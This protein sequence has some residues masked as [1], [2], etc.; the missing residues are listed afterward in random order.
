MPKLP[1][2]RVVFPLLP[3][4]GGKCACGLANCPQI[5]KHPAV[6]WKE[7]TADSVVPLP[8]PGAGYGVRTG[9][10]PFG[11]GCIVVDLDSEAACAAFES[12]G[13]AP[14]TYTVASPRGL[15]LYFTHPGFCVRNSRSKLASKIDVRGDGGMVV[16]PGS[17]HKSGARYEL[18][19]DAPLADPP[20]WLRAW[21]EKTSTTPG[22]IA[23]HADDVEGEDL[24]YHEDLY[25][26]YLETAKPAVDG[27]GGDEQ[28]WR[29]VQRGAYDLA[30]PGD[31]VLS[32][33]RDVY[34][35]RCSPPWDE[36]ALTERVTHKV[37]QAKTIS[38][39]R[40]EEP[41]PLALASLVPS[42]W[43]DLE[44][45]KEERTPEAPT[46]PIPSDLA[47]LEK[48]LKLT[49]GSWDV[50][51]T[52][53]RFIVQ[54][55]VPE[56][57]VGMFVAKGSSLKTWMALSIGIAVAN[58]QP[59]LGTYAVR[60][61]NVLIVDF[62]SGAWQLRDRARI[63]GKHSSPGLGHAN[64]P[65][66]RIDD[67]NF[68][69]KLALICRA[70]NVGLLIIDSFAAGATGV[71]ENDANAAKPL[72]LAARFT[73]LCKCAVLIIHHAKKGEGGDERDLVRGT[74]A[75]YAGLDWAYT[76][77]PNDDNRTRMTVRNIKPFAMRPD[78]FKIALLPEA[79]G[80]VL[81]VDATEK[82]PQEEGEV[83]KN[84]IVGLLAKGPLENKELIARAL[85]MR[86]TEVR[87]Y[88]DALTVGRV[89]V[90][91]AK[92]GYTLDNPAARRE[93]ILKVVAGGRATTF[94]GIAKSAHVDP[95]EVMALK[96]EGAIVMDMGKEEYQ[97]NALAE[98]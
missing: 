51:L 65:S 46:A 20:E 45:A 12:L 81:D 17:P 72:Y 52:P 58:G 55:L 19:R 98:V 31:V 4:E 2:T 50:E 79:G 22:P 27:A 85:K 89:V 3:F 15:H 53:P 30:L 8:L 87:T 21:L 57:T 82:T 42:P 37:T 66:G 63:L 88:L 70:R 24:K 35:P 28:L 73:E 86:D 9:A 47:S 77:I 62:E 90:K 16:G 32:A 92:Q 34:N 83:I 56:E 64:F 61:T 5:G 33:V 14:E 25:R 78:D 18:L 29:V 95:E 23:A 59:W 67:E 41:V 44:A 36:D 94:T 43:L 11:S 39:R 97:V 13:G 74:G 71:D 54:D 60:Q 96:T 75:I 7:L 6:S 1:F 91:L 80:L 48:E 76:L 84:K 10:A 38:T 68:W 93:R 49:W 40:R 69:K 26:E